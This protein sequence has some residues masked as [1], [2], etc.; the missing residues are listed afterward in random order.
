MTDGT[1]EGFRQ[2]KI[3]RQVMCTVK[4]VYE[5]VLQVKEGT[6]VQRENDILIE[7]G[8][9]Y[10]MEMK[11]EQTKVMKATIFSTDYEVPNTTGEC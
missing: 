4:S 1:L 9:Y 7:I 11:V 6:A 5:L 2:F 10:R 8:R 3:G